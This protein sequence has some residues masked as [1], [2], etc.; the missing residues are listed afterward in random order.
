MQG[1]FWKS[2]GCGKGHDGQMLTRGPEDTWERA[3]GPAKRGL[4]SPEERNP[5]AVG[6]RCGWPAASSSLRPVEPPPL[7]CLPGP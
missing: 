7:A 4:R 5:E 6:S 1:V 2:W 3:A